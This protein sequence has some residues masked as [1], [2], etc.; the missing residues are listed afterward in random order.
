MLKEKAT[1]YYTPVYDYNCAEAMIHAANDMYKLNLPKEALK[2][3]AGFGGGM[4][5]ESTCGALAGGVAV[6]GIMF[7]NQKAHESDKM[8]NLVTELMRR[9]EKRMGTIECR[10][11]KDLY[12]EEPPVK[13]RCIV[14]EAADILE[15]IIEENRT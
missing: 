2:T 3:M 13:C 7:V 14:A 12:R 11:L 15:Q 1:S 6:L 4:V 9:F 10:E 5:I 8:K